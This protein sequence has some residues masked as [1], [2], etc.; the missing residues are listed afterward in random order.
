[1]KEIYIRYKSNELNDLD[2]DDSGIVICK[3][4]IDFP[5]GELNNDY[6]PFGCFS[7]R[8]T[9]KRTISEYK[10]ALRSKSTDDDYYTFI[11]EYFELYGNL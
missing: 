8:E 10:R 2:I 4:H 3:K 7:S 9:F 5:T 1:M 11:D 6:F